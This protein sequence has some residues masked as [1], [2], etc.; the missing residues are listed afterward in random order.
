MCQEK[1]ACRIPSLAH[2]RSSLLQDTAPGQ[3][4]LPAA[5]PSQHA[6]IHERSKTVS[7]RYRQHTIRLQPLM[8]LDKRMLA[9]N[10]LLVEHRVHSIWTLAD[11]YDAPCPS[12]LYLAA[13]TCGP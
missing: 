2:V 4:K 11:S 5:S 12:L 3:F 8:A 7:S 9:R 6:G 1:Q 10:V 13:R